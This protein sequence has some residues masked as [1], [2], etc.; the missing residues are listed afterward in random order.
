MYFGSPTELREHL[1]I[2]TPTCKTGQKN[3]DL[4]PVT[5]PCVDD[6]AVA[7]PGLVLPG[8][9]TDECHPYFPLQKTG[10]HF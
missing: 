8:A 10:D 1:L 9:A 5:Q 2:P 3:V 7:S 6:F 4:S